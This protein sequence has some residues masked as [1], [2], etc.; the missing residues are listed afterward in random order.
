MPPAGFEPTIL[1]CERPQTYA[2]DRAATGTGRQILAGRSNQGKRWDRH[3]V[4]V[5]EIKI[6]NAELWSGNCRVRW[7]NI[8]KMDLKFMGWDM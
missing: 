8:I 7:R 4:R 2:L 5:G 1:A 6:C 3:V